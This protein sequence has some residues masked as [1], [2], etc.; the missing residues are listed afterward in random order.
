MT[1]AAV[2]EFTL[3]T[4]IVAISHTRMISAFGRGRLAIRR[5]RTKAEPPSLA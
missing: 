1:S 2:I 4:R 5:C 3:P